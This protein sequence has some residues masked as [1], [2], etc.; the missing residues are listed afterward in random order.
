MSIKQVRNENF[1]P[2]IDDEGF[3]E[4]G[5]LP[6]PPDFNSN[7]DKLWYDNLEPHMRLY[8][9]NTLSSARRH[10]N[11]INVRFAVFKTIGTKLFLLEF[12][13]PKGFP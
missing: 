3:F 13:I 9:H 1:K 5:G 10:A 11:F 12:Q 6:E 2:S 7:K 4:G 8:H